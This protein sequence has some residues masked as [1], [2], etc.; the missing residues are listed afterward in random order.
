MAKLT[1][2]MMA[3]LD[4]YINDL[5]GDFDWGQIDDEVH[6]HANREARRIGA[7]VYGRR[8]YETMAVWETWE[9]DQPV[10][11]EFA[12]AWRSLDKIVVSRTLA[13]VSTPRTR[14]VSTLSL[15]EMARLKAEAHKDIG[16]SGPTLASAY[17][18]GG[19]VDEVSVYTIPI[20]VGSGTPMFKDLTRKL[21]LERLEAQA[22]GNGVTFA[23]YRVRG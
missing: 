1:Y 21:S 3:S 6:A 18:D 10:E 4:G 9:P 13:A 5:S 22:F 20:V 14:L 23:R 7:E 15:E 17:L 11:A 16:I 8:M 19:L 2:Q 12:Q